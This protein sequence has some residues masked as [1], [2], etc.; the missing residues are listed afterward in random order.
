MKKWQK[1]RTA[2]ISIGLL[3]TM[4]A[5][6]ACAGCGG[7][8]IGEPDGSGTIKPCPPYCNAK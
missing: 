5:L 8:H 6:L 1:R 7:S 2:K 3:T 4:A